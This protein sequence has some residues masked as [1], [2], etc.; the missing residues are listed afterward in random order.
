MYSG[1]LQTKCREAEDRERFLS[2]EGEEVQNSCVKKVEASI[3]EV[4]RK[5]EGVLEDADSRL[6]RVVMKEFKEEYIPNQL[7]SYQLKLCTFIDEKRS[8]MLAGASSSLGRVHEEAKTHM[9]GECGYHVMN[10]YM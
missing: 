4:K 2:V 3:T 8:E 6:L 1:E 7:E 10:M 5:L 9:I